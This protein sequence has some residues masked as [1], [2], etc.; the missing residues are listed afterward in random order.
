M[1]D[2][3]NIIF[4]LPTVVFTI[5]MGVLILYW[6]F[7]ILGAL[8]LDLFDL[9]VDIDADVDFDVDVDVDIDVDVDVDVD[10]D[11]DIDG[12]SIGGVGVIAGTLYA[13]GW[14][15]V[16]LTITLSVFILLNWTATFIATFY[17]RTFFEGVV[18]T[19]A[20]LGVLAASLLVCTFATSLVIRPL[21]SA[22]KTAPPRK[23]AMG[24]LGR[25][26]TITSSEI[27]NRTGRAYFEDTDGTHL[28][29]AVR[30]DH[31]NNGLVRG[32]Q[33]LVIGYDEASHVYH[34]EPMGS[35]LDTNLSN[36]DMDVVF[37]Q[38]AKEEASKST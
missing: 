22:M 18:G 13:I 20:R 5:F 37:D 21:R 34:I 24:F 28:D 12:S 32:S 3:L 26:V 11:V 31:D 14:T 2:F 4:S 10:M 27:T 1:K 15:G 6:V 30:C 17:L 29:L 16:P 35:M 25:S 38:L 7:V 19:P 36:K 33:A 23:G 9:D 8:D